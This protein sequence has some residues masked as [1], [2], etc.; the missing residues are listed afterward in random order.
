MKSLKSFVARLILSTVAACVLIPAQSSFSAPKY[1]DT[2]YIPVTFYDFHSDSSNPEFEII[3]TPA[4]PAVK[5]G[6]VANRLDAD[7][8]P[9]VG[10]SPYFNR[11]IDRWFRSWEP[12]DSVIYNYYNEYPA[13]YGRYAD[14]PRD[15]MV[16]LNHDTSFINKVFKDSLSF[17]LI[18]STTGTYQFYDS[19]FFP[20]D[21]KGFG[22]EG[23]TDAAGNLHNFAFAME[24]H[25]EF[26]KVP[27]LT[28][29]F[30]GDDDVWAFVD[31]Q[32]QMDLGGIHSSQIGSINLDGL[33][34]LN[35]YSRYSFDFF[36]V[37]RHVVDSRIRITTNLLTPIVSVDID[38]SPNDTICPFTEV[39]LTSRVR[40]DVTGDRPDL[41]ANTRW[42]VLDLNGQSPD[43]L[44]NNLGQTVTFM[45]NVA[46]SRVILEGSV[47]A[48]G[49]DTLRDTIVIYVQPCEA[50][51]IYIEPNPVDTTDTASLR[52]PNEL[53]QISILDTMVKSEAYAIA[54]DISGA[55]VR[56]ADSIKTVWSITPDGTAI[57]RAEGM[58][59]K[60][61]HGIIT[62]IGDFGETHA[63]AEEP[64]LL[65]DSVP[66]IIAPYYIVRLELR[67]TLG[68]KVTSIEMTTD[69][70]RR[71]VVW[72]LK[73]THQHDPSKPDSWVQVNVTW[74]VTEGLKFKNALPERAQTWTM[75]PTEPGTGTLTLTNPDDNRTEQ[76]NVP[77]VITRADPSSVF[78]RLIT[79]PRVAGDTLLCEVEIHNGDGLVP[80]RYCFG[81][82]GDDL[83]PAV[84]SDTLGTGGGRHPHPTLH[85]DDPKSDTLLNVLNQSVIMN[86]QCFENGIDTIKVVLYYAPFEPFKSDSLHQ[87][88]VTLGPGLKA[89]TERFALLA[90]FLDSL[91]IEDANYVSLPPQT[92]SMTGTISVAPHSDG[93]DQYGNR[94]GFQTS[95]WGTTGTLYEIND[96]NYRTYITA[97]GVTEDQSGEV[98]ATAYSPID[99]SP[100]T[101]CLHVT[102]EGPKRN[103]TAA[104]TR[105]LNG[106]GLLDAIE[107]NFDGV[108]DIGELSLNNFT[109]IAYAST[110]FSADSIIRVDSNTLY[111]RLVETA[112]PTVSQTSWKL[113]F[114]ISGSST[115]A[116]SSN[117]VT[118]DGA[119]PVIMKVTQ[120]VANKL[121]TVEL[122]EPV[123]KTNGNTLQISDSPSVTFNVYRKNIE[124][125]FDTIPLLDSVNSFYQVRRD[126]VLTF[127]MSDEKT[128]A[129]NNYMNLEVQPPLVQDNA[130]NTPHW[131][132]IKRQVKL[133]NQIESMIIAPN[134]TRPDFSH[135][136]A[137]I[138]NFNN[139]PRHIEWARQNKGVLIQITITPDVEMSAS[140]QVHDQI[141][142]LV[143]SVYEPDFRNYVLTHSTENLEN[144]PVWTLN[145]YWNG[146]GKDGMRAAPG[147]YRM[148][149]KCKY[150]NSPKSNIELI[151]VLGLKK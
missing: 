9:V 18:D 38:I 93:Y 90:S 145:F 82:G 141:G 1:E 36:Y 8:K 3:P 46:Y 30:E 133:I 143:N 42:R 32:L 50:Y 27:G 148:V 122:S 78:I 7:M 45:P 55:Y 95:Q 97:E 24:L 136:G 151:S 131:D 116:D 83:N 31:T 69:D 126:S 75:D 150:K 137:G 125:M 37:E 51:K 127:Y 96:E 99:N 5:L 101:A 138:L 16:K 58:E 11:R 132:N 53:A 20:L 112:D 102:I 39:S 124:G 66:V 94:I 84:Y 63:V 28:F 29:N 100:I 147:I 61:Y 33:T 6:M 104:I 4:N 110:M 10:T 146:S 130:S 105:D 120:D 74:S 68:N 140:L 135:V 71:Y 41:A 149:F 35:N 119:G 62:R 123:I 72:G 64:G 67:D 106:N 57:A 107:V 34:S 54:R 87:I 142:N 22:A 79:S 91:A 47:V 128:L 49:R 86:D 108:V 43:A 59:N 26:T 81:R 2:I 76:L 21:G 85:I 139:D 40:D 114:D 12:G 48:N 15:D 117:I 56:L 89:S 70:V 52:Y 98:C 13:R 92:L 103:V 44:R 118:I 73:S 14:L 17:V 19:T 77:V 115:L 25:W 109:N 144:A 134:P 113:Y 121:V 23:R 65:S 60:K 111:L 80:G 88:T 129:S